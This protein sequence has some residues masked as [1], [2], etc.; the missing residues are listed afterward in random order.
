MTPEQVYMTAE[1]IVSDFYYM[2]V[3]DINHIFKSAK[4]GHYGQLYGRIDGQ[5]ILSW[6]EQYSKDRANVA[7]NESYITAQCEKGNSLDTPDRINRI[8]SNLLET[9]EK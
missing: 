9:P 7:A 1:L 4:M 8:I 5:L 2:N 3:A 6:F